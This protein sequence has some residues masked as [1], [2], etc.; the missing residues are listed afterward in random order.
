MA[1]RSSKIW[2]FALKVVVWTHL[3]NQLIIDAEE[4]DEDADDFE[5]FRAEPGRMRLGVFGE[6]GLGRVVQAGLRLLG[7]VR[8]FVLDATVEGFD[9]F[10]VDG[11]LVRL[12]ELDFRRVQRIRLLENFKLDH[13]RGRNDA[14]RDVSKTRGVVAEID[15][16]RPVHVI[17]DLPRDQQAEL[18]GLDVEV[19]I[20]PAEDFFCLH[21]GLQG[22]F[23]LG[24][25]T[26]LIQ[27][28]RLVPDPLVRVLKAER[29][30]LGFHGHVVHRGEYP[31]GLVRRLESS[32][33]TRSSS[34]GRFEDCAGRALLQV[35][36]GFSNLL[37]QAVHLTTH[38]HGDVRIIFTSEKRKTFGFFTDASRQT[39]EFEMRNTIMKNRYLKVFVCYFT[40]GMRG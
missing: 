33:R 36:Q 6:A 23:A 39:F 30:R 28:L 1:I 31:G 21:G 2:M 20:P 14:H 22:R 38:T 11:G 5:G 27:Q 26:A 7:T 29:G 24:P 18:E 37:L 16:E 35:I 15:G 9:V 10:G 4:G 8:F 32:C 25:V 40:L 12:V 19:E 13:L 3:L 17:H 34:Q